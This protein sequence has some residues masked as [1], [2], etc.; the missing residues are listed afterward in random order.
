[1]NRLALA[2]ALSLAAC[3]VPDIN[4]NV[5]VVHDADEG[6]DT[7]EAQDTDACEPETPATSLMQFEWAKADTFFAECWN[8]TRDNLDRCLNDETRSYQDCIGTYDQEEV[9]C[10]YWR[11]ERSNKI[12]LRT[13]GVPIFIQTSADGDPYTWVVNEADEDGDNIATWHEYWMGINPCTTHSFGTCAEGDAEW[14]Y[15]ADGIPNGEDPRPICNE[16]ST[17][18]AEY[19]SD[20]V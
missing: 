20:C 12:P 6:Q 16:S 3:D 4:L 7:D 11:N 1:M 9:R 17:D 8:E 19:Y 15:D 2:T 14:D 18:P 5:T 13:C 10:Y